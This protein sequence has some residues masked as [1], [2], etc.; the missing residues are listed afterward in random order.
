MAETHGVQICAFSPRSRPRRPG[1]AGFII[2]RWWIAG[3]CQPQE[4][5]RRKAKADLRGKANEGGR[6]KVLLWLAC[7]QW[8]QH[9]LI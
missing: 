9:R 1:E 6:L 7:R 5:T 3:M 4:P 2:A 8:S